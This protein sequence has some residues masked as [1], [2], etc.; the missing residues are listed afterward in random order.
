MLG[1]ILGGGDVDDAGSGEENR[2]K[3]GPAQ[4]D[5]FGN[6]DE[7]PDIA[8]TVFSIIG[9]PV[10]LII[11]LS[12]HCKQA[13]QLSGRHTAPPEHNIHKVTAFKH[14]VWSS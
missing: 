1:L 6:G 8:E 13:V 2:V 12:N 4:A 3:L 7:P 9:Q 14:C 10:E 5:G 11:T